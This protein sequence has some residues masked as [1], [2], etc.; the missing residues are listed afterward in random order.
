MC[1]DIIRIIGAGFWRKGRIFLKQKT[2]DSIELYDED[3]PVGDLMRVKDMLP[4]PE[5]L[6][7]GDKSVK[8]TISL[9]EG[10]INFFKN[11]A[12][13]TGQKYQRLIRAV[14]KGY[15]ERWK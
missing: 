13:K 3:M 4:P 6:L 9:D 14:L 10:T 12:K 5:E 11:S 1:G 7:P 2:S 15:A 8:I